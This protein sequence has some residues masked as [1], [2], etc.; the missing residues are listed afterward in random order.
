M[1]TDLTIRSTGLNK[2]D[3]EGY[4]AY[5]GLHHLLSLAFHKMIK[6]NVKKAIFVSTR[7][8]STTLVLKSKISKIDATELV[9]PCMKA[10]I[11][12]ALF[13]WGKND[14]LKAIQ[15]KQVTMN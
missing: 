1:V 9:F 14:P 6:K 4:R 11:L 2:E 5:L 10:C 15:E 3:G 7:S 8:L 12:F 13:S